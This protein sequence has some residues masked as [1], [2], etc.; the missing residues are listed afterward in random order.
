MQILYGSYDDS[1]AF[2]GVTSD[3]LLADD[4]E[5]IALDMAFL[6]QKPDGHEEL[7]RFIADHNIQTEGGPGWYLFGYYV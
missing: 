5:Y 1:P 7:D 6:S 4:K 2:I 3:G